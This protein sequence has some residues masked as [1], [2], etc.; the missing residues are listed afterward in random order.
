MEESF[1]RST[2]ALQHPFRTL[3]V[4]LSVL[5][6][7]LRICSLACVAPADQLRSQLGHFL[8]VLSIA[9]GDRLSPHLDAFLTLVHD[10]TSMSGTG[11]PHSRGSQHS[12]KAL[13]MSDL[14]GRVNR[15]LRGPPWPS[16][17]QFSRR[18][19]VL[20]AIRL[21]SVV[22]T[23]GTVCSHGSP[24]SPSQCPEPASRVFARAAL[25]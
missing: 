22:T 17:D 4:L 24:C 18:S 21:R 23:S 7:S 1:R 15:L 5:P 2:T 6:S 20:R 9:D 13:Q 8:G 12:P 16:E 3:P 14:E 25:R 11:R 10:F 19:L